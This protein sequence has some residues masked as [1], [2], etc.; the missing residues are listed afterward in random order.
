MGTGLHL[1]NAEMS[2]ISEGQDSLDLQEAIVN[3]LLP[4]LPPT[5]CPD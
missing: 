2:A 3:L 5:L 4:L 1:G